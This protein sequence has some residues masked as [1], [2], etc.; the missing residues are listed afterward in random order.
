MAAERW[1]DVKRGLESALDKD[2]RRRAELRERLGADNLHLREQVESLLAS[3]HSFFDK[4]PDSLE[5]V[6]GE[7]FS[8]Q[9]G[10][11]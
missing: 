4:T 7:P 3:R 2:P 8:A 9:R 10:R 5:L 6:G 1:H 11:T